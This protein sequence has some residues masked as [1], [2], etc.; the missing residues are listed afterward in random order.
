MLANGWHAGVARFWLALLLTALAQPTGAAPLPATPSPWGGCCLDRVR[1]MTQAAGLTFSVGERPPRM[2]KVA[3]IKVEDCPL[4]HCAD[5]LRTPHPFD[6]AS[7]LEDTLDFALTFLQALGPDV[8]RWRRDVLAEIT[9]LVED[10]R[11]ELVAWFRSLQE[12]AQKANLSPATPAGMVAVPVLLSLGLLIRY[13]A[14]SSS[15]PTSP[16]ASPSW[17]S[18]HQAPAGIS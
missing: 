2:G 16:E 13:P 7:P 5:A 17:G 3:F 10:S 6:V 4:Q 9:H 18:S 8:A 1:L 11:E 12:H 15:Q 14:M